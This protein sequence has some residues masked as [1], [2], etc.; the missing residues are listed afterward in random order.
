MRKSSVLKRELPA[1]IKT[2]LTAAFILMLL[3]LALAGTSQADFW[4]TNSSVYG[5][6]TIYGTDTNATITIDLPA[7]N[8]AN[9]VTV[10]FTI[11]IFSSIEAP[12]GN[13][14]NS[15]QYLTEHSQNLFDCYLSSGFILDYDRAK[16]IDTLW[17][18]WGKSGETYK[19]EYNELLLNSY[20]SILSQTTDSYHG[21]TVLSELSERSHNLTAWVRAEQNYLSFDNPIWVAF[22]DTITFNIDATAPKVSVLSPRDS[23]YNISDVQLNFVVSEPFSQ[24]IYSLDEQE[25]VTISGNT[26]LTG[27]PNGDHNVTVYATD[28][29]GN[30]GSETISFSVDVPFPTALVATAFIV[31]VSVVGIGMA[32]YFKKRK[33]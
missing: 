2:L 13:V 23:L 16:I 17:L 12:A 20:D 31:A 3:L 10:A 22:S 7:E 1:E 28:K 9:N 29:A 32:V 19:K 21:S 4:S 26:T 18:N 24:V 11:K 14:V 5:N 33:R 8:K 30:V 25:N 27:L 6:T 15:T